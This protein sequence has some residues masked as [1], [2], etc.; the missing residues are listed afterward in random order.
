MPSELL[1]VLQQAKA[2]AKR[3]RELTARP[4]G[5]S[6]EIGEYEAARLLGLELAEV[7]RAGYDAVRRV[8]GK[9]ERLQI[10]TRCVLS[11]SKPGQRVGR[12][13]LQKEWDTVLLV[14][15]NEDFEAT[16]IYEADRP[17]VETALK[18]PGSKARNER[19]AMAVNKFKSIG[20]KIWPSKTRGILPNDEN[21]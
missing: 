16:G 9:E 7:R 15:L 13:E 20:R 3:Y 5:I 4:L 17:A 8:D 18:A 11:G 21:N 6:G 14:L 10:K 1:V 19:G 2:L 12:I